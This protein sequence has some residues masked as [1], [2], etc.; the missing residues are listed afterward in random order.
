MSSLIKYQPQSVS[1]KAGRGLVKGGLAA[2]GLAL[3]PFVGVV[4]VAVVAVLGG[5]ALWLLT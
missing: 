4:P 1:A 5:A 2:L 3:V